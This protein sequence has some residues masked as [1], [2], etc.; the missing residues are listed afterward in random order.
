MPVICTLRRSISALSKCLHTLSCFL[1][2]HSP[3]PQLWKC[4]CR[5]VIII[6]TVTYVISNYYF[7]LYFRDNPNSSVPYHYYNNNNQSGKIK[8]ECEY[9]MKSERKLHGGHLFVTE[10][11]IFGRWARNYNITFRHPEWS[12]KNYSRSSID[13]PFMKLFRQKHPQ[14]S[15]SNET[16]NFWEN[17]TSLQDSVNSYKAESNGDFMV[18]WRGR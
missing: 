14:N 5:H 6:T 10:K 2:I 12:K 3:P 15:T 8:K 13:T 18:V 1:V 4:C 16:D 17:K 7:I 9:Y 11:F